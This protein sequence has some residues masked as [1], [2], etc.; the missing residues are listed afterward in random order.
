MSDLPTTP[1]SPREA[2]L[3]KFWRAAR[4]ALPDAGLGDAYQV[5]WIGL[6]DQT[7]EQIF[8]LIRAGDKTGTFTLPWLVEQNADPMP[9]VGDA[10]ILVSFD[11]TPK[12]LLRLTEI[13]KVA[14]GDVTEAHTAVDGSPVRALEIWKPLHT[15]Y[16]NERLQPFGL[17]V[18]DDMPVLVE[19]FGV[20]YDAPSSGAQE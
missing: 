19:K 2:E 17:S 12:I 18:R 4:A 1:A 3:A 5:R 20:L 15:A 14:F 16:W 7:T 10:I 13:A 11:G 8:E 6:D 9:R